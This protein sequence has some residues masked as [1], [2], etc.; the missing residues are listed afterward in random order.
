LNTKCWIS[1]RKCKWSWKLQQALFNYFE[2]NDENLPLLVHIIIFTN[3]CSPSDQQWVESWEI[4]SAGEADPEVKT[5]FVF[6]EAGLPTTSLLLAVTGTFKILFEKKLHGL[7]W[8][9]VAVSVLRM[10]KS[11]LRLFFSIFSDN[12]PNLT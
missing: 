3:L 12:L 2:W 9:E 5:I 6:V 11:H 1:F 8:K 7:F 4:P 10:S